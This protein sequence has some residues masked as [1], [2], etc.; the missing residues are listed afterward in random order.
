MPD[1][2]TSASS[3]P[4]CGHNCITDHFDDLRDDRVAVSRKLAHPGGKPIIQARKALNVRGPIRRPVALYIS[5]L[6]QPEER[7]P[8]QTRG[9]GSIFLKCLL[10]FPRST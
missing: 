7:R 5:V 2:G 6:L 9:V 3:L 1:E 4:A 8:E 10:W